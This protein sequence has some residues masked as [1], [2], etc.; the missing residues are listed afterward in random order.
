MKSHIYFLFYKYEELIEWKVKILKSSLDFLGSVPYVK[1]LLKYNVIKYSL[2]ATTQGAIEISIV[3][4][5]SI[6]SL[7]YVYKSNVQMIMW[8][9]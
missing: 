6:A 8:F 3:L 9:I 7:S 1:I 2:W 4:Y 5:L